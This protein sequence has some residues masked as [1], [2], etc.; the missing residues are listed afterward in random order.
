M[1]RQADKFV[2]NSDSAWTHPP[3]K[4]GPAVCPQCDAIMVTP[5]ISPADDLHDGRRE[6]ADPVRPPL[7]VVDVSLP[8][9]V[10]VLLQHLQESRR[11]SRAQHT[12]TAAPHTAEGGPWAESHH[13]D[14]SGANVEGRGVVEVP[15]VLQGSDLQN[16]GRICGGHAHVTSGHDG[17]LSLFGSIFKKSASTEVRGCLLRAEEN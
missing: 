16:A 17:N 12:I 3:L 1:I 15:V 5:T 11:A 7:A 8:A 2:G 9:P 6:E 13:N 14:V 10:R 4:V